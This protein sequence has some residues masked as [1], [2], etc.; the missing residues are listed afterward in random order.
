MLVRICPRWTQVLKRQSIVAPSVLLYCWSY[1]AYVCVVIW[2]HSTPILDDP[3]FP[4]QPFWGYWFPQFPQFI[5]ISPIL[6]CQIILRGQPGPAISAEPE[7]QKLHPAKDSSNDQPRPIFGVIEPIGT[8][9]G[10]VWKLIKIGYIY[11]I[12]NIYIHKCIRHN[13]PCIPPKWKNKC[14]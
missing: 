10:S 3:D 14:Y 9:H 2:K 5:L 8:P 13:Y 1:L 6:V 7:L 12:H 11:I 4:F